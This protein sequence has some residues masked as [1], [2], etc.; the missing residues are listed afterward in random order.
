MLFTSTKVFLILDGYYIEGKKNPLEKPEDQ[1]RVAGNHDFYIHKENAEGYTCK[2][3]G[4]DILSVRV[5]HPIHFKPGVGGGEC[6]YTEAP[7]CPNCEKKPDSSG[8]PIIKSMN[9]FN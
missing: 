4:T 7:Y 2:E 5:A 3:C 9:W 1:K 8:D 6:E